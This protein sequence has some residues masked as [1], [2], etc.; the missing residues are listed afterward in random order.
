MFNDKFTRQTIALVCIS[1]SAILLYPAAQSGAEM[2]TWALL[3][4]TGL[5]AVITINTK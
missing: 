4:V 1:L 5:A 3:G 2:L